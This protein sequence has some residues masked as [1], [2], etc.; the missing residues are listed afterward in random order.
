MKQVN[1]LTMYELNKYM[2]AVAQEAGLTLHPSDKGYSYIKGKAIYL[3]AEQAPIDPERAMRN[4][5]RLIH[6]L[7]HH[8]HTDNKYWSDVPLKQ[9]SL[10]RSIWNMLEDHRTEYTQ[11]QD[12]AGDADILDAGYASDLKSVSR[13]LDQVNKTTHDPDTQKHIDFLAASLKFDREL[14]VD[15]Q[16]SAFEADVTLTPDQQKIYESMM[17]HADTMRKART[18]S[19]KAGTK[20]MHEL[21]RTIYEETGGDPDKDE[22]EGKQA[23]AKGEARGH[24]DEPVD[25]DGEPKGDGEKGEGEGKPKP[26]PKSKAEEMSSKLSTS[27]ENGTGEPSGAKGYSGRGSYTPALPEEFFVHNAS[28]PHRG[29]QNR[30]VEDVCGSGGWGARMA[31]EVAAIRAA[32]SNSEQLATKMRRL[33]QIRTRSRTVYAQK[34]GKLHG[35]SLHRIVSKVP[36]YSERVFKRKEEHLDIDSAVCVAVD[37]S[38][39]MRGDKISHAM[40]AAEMLSETVGNALGIPLMIYGF[41]EGRPLS[42]ASEESPTIFVLRDYTDHQLSTEKLRERAEFCVGH[43]MGNNPDA[44]AVIW[45][46]HQLRAAKGKR[47][48]LFVLSDGSPATCRSGD[49]DRYL[50]EVCKL[51]ESSPIKLFG[52]GLMDDSVRYYY[53][54]SAVVNNA[55]QIEPKIIELVDNFI[56]E[57]K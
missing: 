7:G 38:G 57:G 46:Y 25:E 33:V 10:L 52:L 20:L 44:D 11:S 47:K 15:W 14:R 35:A 6:E 36:G 56:L 34:Q 28:A 50:K 40:A 39:S 32:H 18:V 19:G 51:I 22:E 2:K 41:S 24:G 42:H 54:R 4:L 27:P 16:P 31:H 29:S 43:T 13:K 8:F 49:Q 21:A 26:A 48:I 9:E 17:K 30:R 53:K 55:A 5:R 3:A 12:Y 37:C 23:A 45:G 1:V